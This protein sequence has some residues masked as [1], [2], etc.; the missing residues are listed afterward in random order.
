MWMEF[1]RVVY[2]GGDGS[3]EGQKE[4]SSGELH[5]RVVGDVEMDGWQIEHKLRTAMGGESMVKALNYF[6]HYICRAELR[7]GCQ[8]GEATTFVVVFYQVNQAPEES[9]VLP[10]STPLME[11]AKVSLQLQSLYVSEAFVDLGH[12]PDLTGS[13]SLSLTDCEEPSHSKF[14][15]G[16]CV[17]FG[18]VPRG[19]DV[20]FESS[21]LIVE[22]YGTELGIGWKEIGLRRVINKPGHSAW[23]AI[24]D[25][26]F[27]PYYPD[28]FR[29]VQAAT[30][31]ASNISNIMLP[32]SKHLRDRAAE[33][34]DKSGHPLTGIGL[35][36][37]YQGKLKAMLMVKDSKVK[38]LTSPVNHTPDVLKEVL[39]CYFL[40]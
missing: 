28:M 33:V 19:A 34:S 8:L 35:D 37:L 27:A 6:I 12:F 14:L 11:A 21:S 30:A 36:V 22:K 9:T 15:H 39:R 16:R 10:P 25:F 40:K 32:M 38:T 26:Q 17:S 2:D 13:K 20:A 5:F 23:S 24:A 29:T 31:N 18:S 4:E 7:R 3:D 1:Y